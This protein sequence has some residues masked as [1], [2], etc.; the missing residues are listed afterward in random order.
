MTI[1]FSDFKDPCKQHHAN[2]CLNNYD[3]A[4]TDLTDS[5]IYFTFML[6][7]ILIVST[8]LLKVQSQ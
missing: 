7:I 6:G 1:E 8:R 3:S 5:A 2:M 4:L